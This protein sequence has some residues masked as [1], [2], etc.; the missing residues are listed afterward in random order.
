M[1]RSYGDRERAPA[2]C[3]VSCTSGAAMRMHQV[4]LVAALPEP[5]ILFF[6]ARASSPCGA[7]RA[8]L[9]LGSRFQVHHAPWLVNSPR[10]SVFAARP[11]PRRPD[12]RTTDASSKHRQVIHERTSAKK[13]PLPLMAIR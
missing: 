13:V 1:V 3:C 9:F 5:P 6:T 10:G 11:T 7:R 2:R 12:P 4:V 8:L